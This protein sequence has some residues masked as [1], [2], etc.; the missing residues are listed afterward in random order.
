M[1]Y[2]EHNYRQSKTDKCRLS[3]KPQNIKVE[4]DERQLPD[5]CKPSVGDDNIC[6]GEREQESGIVSPVRKSEGIPLIVAYYA[7]Y[8]QDK[9]HKNGN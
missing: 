7:E 4:R 9:Q 1:P 8:R 6:Q 5:P 3:S 2:H